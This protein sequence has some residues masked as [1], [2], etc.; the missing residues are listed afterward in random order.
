MLDMYGWLT[1][2]IGKYPKKIKDDRL[3]NL[4]MLLPEVNLRK[5]VNLKGSCSSDDKIPLAKLVKRWGKERK[6]SSSE[7][8]IHLIELK[9]YT[10]IE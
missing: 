8:D 2:T 3:E 7:K 10:K 5:K 9:K 4:F 6:N 1:L